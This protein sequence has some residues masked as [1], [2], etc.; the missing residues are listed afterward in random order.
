MIL[1]YLGSTVSTFAH[2]E[3]NEHGVGHLDQDV[4]HAVH[5]QVLHPPLLHVLQHL[6]VHQRLVQTTVAI[7]REGTGLDGSHDPDVIDR[8]LWIVHTWSHGDLS[9]I[10][11]D[12]LSIKSHSRNHFLLKHND[13]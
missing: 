11:Q 12:D 3:S 2:T 9:F 8:C 13:V 7:C 4:V 5:M 10:L 6:I 1:L